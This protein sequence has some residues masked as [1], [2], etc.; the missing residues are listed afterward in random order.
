MFFRQIQQH[1]DNFSYIIGDE[2][3]N[4]VAVVDSS[5]NAGEIIKILKSQKF[6]LKYVVNTH[7]HSDHIASETLS[8]ALFLVLK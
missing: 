5:Y 4:E 3:S 8:Y 7:G 6:Q 1:G 2:N